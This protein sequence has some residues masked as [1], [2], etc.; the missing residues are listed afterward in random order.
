MDL[1]DRIRAAVVGFLERSLAWIGIDGSSALAGI[2]VFVVTFVGSIALTGALLVRLPSDF[3]TNSAPPPFD[4]RHPKAYFFRVLR[5]LAGVVLILI[6]LVLSIP[7]VPGQGILTIIAG[8]FISELP[9]TRPLLRRILSAPRIFAAVNRLRARY[10]HPPL[11]ARE[12]AP[13]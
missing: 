6:G 8:L 9:G 4:P 1:I 12:P 7:G 2:V 11:E 13:S 10:K 3:L 5:H